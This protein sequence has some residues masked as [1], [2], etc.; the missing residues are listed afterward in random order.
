M[1]SGV[2]CPFSAE[3]KK[4]LCVTLVLGT[5]LVVTVLAAVLVWK[6]CKYGEPHGLAATAQPRLLQSWAQGDPATGAGEAP[7]PLPPRPWP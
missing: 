1:L 4:A 5:F 6:F 2:L 7:R 3:A